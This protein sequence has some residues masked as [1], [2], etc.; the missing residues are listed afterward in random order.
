M[1]KLTKKIINKINELM[2]R[3]YS[4]SKDDTTDE[5]WALG[6]RKKN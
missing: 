1:K 5:H 4:A 2:L 3:S 6:L